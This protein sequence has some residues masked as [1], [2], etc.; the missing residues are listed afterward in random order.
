MIRFQFYKRKT[1]NKTIRKLLGYA[2]LTWLVLLVVFGT[3]ITDYSMITAY[4]NFQSR[5]GW[6]AMALFLG[7]PL[8]VLCAMAVCFGIK[9]RK[10]FT[11]DYYE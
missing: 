9:D 11:E 2:F 8:H 4:N 3:I 10:M 6:W 5:I 7:I 1:M